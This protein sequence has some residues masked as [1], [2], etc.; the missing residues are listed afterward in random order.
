MGEWIRHLF[1]PHHTNNFRAKVLHFDFFVVYMVALVG[2]AFLFRF[3][4]TVSPSILGFATDIR[5][6][7]LVESTNKKRA[8]AGFSPLKYNEKLSQAAAGKA[9]YMFDKDFWAHTAP[10]GTTPWDFINGAGYTYVVAGENL[11]KNFSTSQ[12][13]VE[14]WMNS[15]SHRENLLRSQYEDVGFAVVN[16]RLNGEETTLVVQMFGKALATREP[17]IAQNP[18]PAPII[19]AAAAEAEEPTT[20]TQNT[21]SEPEPTPVPTPIPVIAQIQPS[22]TPFFV[23]GAVFNRPLLDIPWLTKHMLLV[24]SSVLLITLVADAFY[25]WRH[26]IVRL[27]GKQMAHILFLFAITGAVWAVS[28]GS[29]L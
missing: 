18:S 9:A 13:V 28:F 12:E 20:P 29:I 25:V 11:A 4:H 7:A 1:L 22:A 10:D 3:V 6:D 27:S 8:E 5:V 26:K 23:A 24:L 16:G 21:A 14:A 17:Q 15:P 19:P 2:A